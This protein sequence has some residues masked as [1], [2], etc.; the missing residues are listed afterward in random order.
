MA[1]KSVMETQKS[2]KMIPCTN[3]QIQE[4]VIKVQ[5]LV[6]KAQK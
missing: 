6:I 2:L 1:L 4:S 5:N 3:K